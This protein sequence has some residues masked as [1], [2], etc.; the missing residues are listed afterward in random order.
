MPWAEHRDTAQK[1]AHDR[2]IAHWAVFSGDLAKADLRTMR[3]SAA[4]CQQDGAAW[5]L[6]LPPNR[7]ASAAELDLTSIISL[8]P[9]APAP[10]GLFAALQQAGI[11]DVRQLGVIA[12]SRE[13]LDAAHRAGAGAVVGVATSPGARHALVPGQPD[14][15]I[16]PGEFAALDAA[17]YASD[18]AH[19]ERVLL[20]PG[21]AVVSDRVHRA[22]AGPD[23]CHREPEYSDIL[24]NVR[25]RLLAVA[26]VPDD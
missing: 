2:T 21:P 7:V 9:D 18:R 4:A 20:N 26:G 24:D 25:A 14:V 11:A 1:W 16:A 6:V 5:A 3:E 19:R 17:R 13:T 23:L 15:I 12:A 10:F 8:G 22:V